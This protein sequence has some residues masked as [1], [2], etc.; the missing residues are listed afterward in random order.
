MEH[1]LM[2]RDFSEKEDAEFLQH[3]LVEYDSLQH[4]VLN[5]CIHK[6]YEVLEGIE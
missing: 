4:S 5:K 2:R 6:L 1:T 3:M